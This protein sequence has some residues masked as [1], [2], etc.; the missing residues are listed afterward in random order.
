MSPRK[1]EQPYTSKLQGVAALLGELPAKKA[2]DFLALSTITQPTRQPRRYFDPQK[3]QQL[4]QSIKVHGILEPL[5]VRPLTTKHYELVAGERRYRAAMELGLSEVPVVIKDLSDEEALQ[6]A[7]VENLLRVDLNPIEETE[8]ILALLGVYLN[9]KVEKIV[10]LLH[11][12]QNEAKGKV[13]QNV[14]GNREGQKIIEVFQSL[15]T[16]SWES[17]VSSRLPLLNLPSE[18]LEVLRQGLLDYTKAK[19][20]AK[21]KDEQQRKGLLD[22]AIEQDLSL[23]QIKERIQSLQSEAT[24]PTTPQRTLADTYRRLREAKPWKSPQKWK[25]VQTL[26]KKL[27][28]LIE[29]G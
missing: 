14:L 5:L 20:I 9:Q 12:M 11:R 3:Q 17:F 24:E 28:T 16:I 26:L 10:S 21:V 22:E 4:V 23:S 25:K 18:L 19:V 13:T 6:L 1:K 27:E 15:G 29:E 2:T 7:L 8:G